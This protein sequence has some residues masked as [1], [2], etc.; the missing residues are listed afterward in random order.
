[1]EGFLSPCPMQQASQLATA[2][3][4]P[5]QGLRADASPVGE[6][7]DCL[8]ERRGKKW[9]RG[10]R[11]EEILPWPD[12]SLAGADLEAFQTT[13]PPQQPSPAIRAA[14]KAPPGQD[15][16]CLVCVCVQPL[17]CKAGHRVRG[18]LA[19]PQLLLLPPTPENGPG[20][21]GEREG[22]Q[23]VGA[24]APQTRLGFFWIP[25]NAALEI[26]TSHTPYTRR[27]G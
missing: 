20:G 25:G 14:Q 13:P 15:G 24:E 27:L 11:F 18:R 9:R 8:Q 6:A 4:I 26:H 16:R 1:M 21:V 7:R 23:S 2:M 5:A 17:L 3:G 19:S 22:G 10:G 12:T